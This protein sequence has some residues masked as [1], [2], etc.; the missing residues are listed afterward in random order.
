M[1]D[2]KDGGGGFHI[3]KGKNKVNNYGI[4]GSNE[5]IVFRCFSIDPATG[6]VSDMIHIISV[7]ALDPG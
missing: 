7:H 6:N 2:Q 4:I 5:M 1:S 3:K